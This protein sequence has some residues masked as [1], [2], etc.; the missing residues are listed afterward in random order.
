[1][2]ETSSAAPDVLSRDNGEPSLSKENFPDLR[3]FW[4]HEWRG[5]ALRSDSTTKLDN[6]EILARNLPGTIV[7]L[8]VLIFSDFFSAS[9]HVIF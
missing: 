7:T 5:M 6:F 1:M 3:N 8:T 9:V 2:S 4:V